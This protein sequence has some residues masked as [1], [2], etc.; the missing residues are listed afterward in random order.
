MSILNGIDL[1]IELPVLYSISSAENFADGAIKLLNS[2]NAVDCITFGTEVS[3][4]DILDK[5]AKILY[6]EP[7]QYKNLLAHELDKGLSFPKAREN[8]LM[9]CVQN[10][11]KS[12]NVLSYPNNILAIEYLK[13]LKKYKSNILPISIPR[14]ETGY[15]DINFSGH[16]ASATAIRNEILK[17]NFSSLNTITP[18]SSYS[19]IDEERKKGHIIKNI[20]VFDKE[21][22][23]TLRKMS[24]EEIANLQDVSEGL[25]F[26]LKKAANSCNSVAELIHLVNSKRY[27][28]TRIQRILLYA[29]LDITKKD[30][31]ISKKI[32]PYIR[33]L[34]F[35]SKGRFL[36]SEISK[37]NPKL[38]IVTSVKKFLDTNPGKD[39][40]MMLQK[41][42]LASNIY[43]L[44]YEYDSFS[45]LDFTEKLITL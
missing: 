35:N 1:V 13:A 19:I 36:I 43:T 9:M 28:Q 17:D 15:N 39:Y 21:I 25:E 14:V 23:Y 41:D 24:I 16:I 29:L 26:S 10:I 31:Q 2:L 44:G 30:I 27:T 38:K 32:T 6:E 11:R 34:G 40:K 33:V 45:N 42:I 4:I 5:F 18:I 7:S 22:I 12:I 20:G 8:A 37:S 3:N